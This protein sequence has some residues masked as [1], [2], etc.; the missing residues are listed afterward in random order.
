MPGR[1]PEVE[2]KFKQITRDIVMFGEA[3][4]LLSGYANALK[5]I[6]R[7]MSR[8]TKIFI[9]A[10]EQGTYE[11]F[12]AFEDK[13]FTILPFYEMSEEYDMASDGEHPGPEHNRIFADKIRP[14]V[15][16]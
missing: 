1:T 12:R 13:S 9:S 10:Y 6:L 2:K 14:I 7:D 16:G 4:L 15:G 5:V 11:C 8:K 3:S